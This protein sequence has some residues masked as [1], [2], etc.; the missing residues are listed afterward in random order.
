MRK[1]LLVWGVAEFIVAAFTY[2]YSI[3]MAT[4]DI[5]VGAALIVWSFYYDDDNNSNSIQGT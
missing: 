2:K 3:A 4:I 1:V 5:I